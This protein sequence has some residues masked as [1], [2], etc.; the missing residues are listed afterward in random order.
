VEE[1]VVL[2]IVWVL[3][4]ALHVVALAAVSTAEILV[5]STVAGMPV[6]SIVFD[7]S[8]PTSNKYYFFMDKCYL[9]KMY[10]YK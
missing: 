9:C 1:I 3:V 4:D 5:V 10:V 2:L 6:A 7:P 8:K